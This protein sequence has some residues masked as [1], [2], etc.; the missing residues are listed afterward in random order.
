MIKVQKTRESKSYDK[1]C[2][3]EKRAAS[4]GLQFCARSTLFTVF[5]EA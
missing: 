2:L 3:G 4:R 5:G 1:T